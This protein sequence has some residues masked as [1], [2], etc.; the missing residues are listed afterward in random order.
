MVKYLEKRADERIRRTYI[1]GVA[2][3]FVDEQAV[4][5]R[6]GLTFLPGADN[7]QV[8]RQEQSNIAGSIPDQKDAIWRVNTA[9]SLLMRFDVLPDLSIVQRYK[10]EEFT[11]IVSQRSSKNDSMT[12]PRLAKSTAKPLPLF[13]GHEPITIDSDFVK[14]VNCLGI[15]DEYDLHSTLIEVDGSSLLNLIITYRHLISCIGPDINFDET[16]FAL[17]TMTE[18]VRR[19]WIR[20][21]VLFRMSTRAHITTSKDT[22]YG[23]SHRTMFRTLT[24]SQGIREIISLG[25]AHYSSLDFVENTDEMQKII[26]PR[27]LQMIVLLL[28]LLNNDDL[29][30]IAE[31]L[32]ATCKIKA[33]RSHLEI[34]FLKVIPLMSISSSIFLKA[35]VH[36]IEGLP[37][38]ENHNSYCWDVFVGR[39]LQ[40]GYLLPGTVEDL[41]REGMSWIVKWPE[42]GFKSTAVFNNLQYAGNRSRTLNDIPPIEIIPKSSLNELNVILTNGETCTIRSAD[43]ENITCLTPGAYNIQEARQGGRNYDLII[44]EYNINA[45]LSE[46]IWKTNTVVQKLNALSNIIREKVRNHIF[47]NLRKSVEITSLY[48][49]KGSGRITRSVAVLNQHILAEAYKI[50]GRKITTKDAMRTMMQDIR[51]MNQLLEHIERRIVNVPNDH[52]EK[53]TLRHELEEIR[54][55]INVLEGTRRDLANSDIISDEPV[56]EILYPRG[57][58]ANCATPW[59]DYLAWNNPRDSLL[60]IEAERS[61]VVQIVWLSEG[62]I[63]VKLAGYGAKFFV[64]PLRPVLE[65]ARADEIRVGDVAILAGQYMI[66]AEPADEQGGDSSHL[67]MTNYLKLISVEEAITTR[68]GKNKSRQV[69]TKVVSLFR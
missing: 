10:S 57:V 36:A 18:N 22:R 66:I 31:F 27:F 11:A 32:E 12:S 43:L 1:E 28:S 48:E 68:R 64:T 52:S 56:V 13:R 42:D 69:E 3:P 29:V 61:T 25:A 4:F 38:P 19:L 23:V 65:I 21:P 33:E 59:H 46:A 34:L 30:D 44:H 39:M 45:D 16:K 15:D 67:S 51:E 63:E 41:G 20:S 37:I 40:L 50:E 54:T 35:L 9:A 6:V 62:N 17:D 58:N 47:K 53:R 7:L 8:T 26:R 24:T 14:I 2:M 60:Y 49:C 55:H 5:L